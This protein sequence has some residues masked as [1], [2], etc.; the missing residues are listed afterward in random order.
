[1]RLID[2]DLVD[3][4]HI[5]VSAFRTRT[6]QERECTNPNQSGLEWYWRTLEGETVGFDV[7][8]SGAIS[9]SAATIKMQVKGKTR[10]EHFRLV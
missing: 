8:L 7:D 3:P 2:G 4:H 1:M 5:R 10:G 6:H 9:D